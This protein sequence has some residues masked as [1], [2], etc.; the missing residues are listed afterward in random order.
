MLYTMHQTKTQED[1]EIKK[2]KQ[3]FEMPTSLVPWLLGFWQTGKDPV[4]PEIS[5]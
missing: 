2:N 4:T 3:T 5:L 1:F